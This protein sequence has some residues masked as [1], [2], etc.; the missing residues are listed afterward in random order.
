MEWYQWAATLGIPSI[1]S[2]L[3]CGLIMLKI[4]R[5]IARSDEE[6]KLADAAAKTRDAEI[7]AQN[8]TMEK[9][10]RAMM[11]GMQAM[12]RD[13]LLQAYRHYETKGWAD[14]DDRENLENIY[15]QYHA[16][17]ANGIM[18]EYRNRFLALPTTP[19]ATVA[20]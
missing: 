9:Q 3:I 18:D 6:K 14:Y 19:P 12:L 2:G 15:T 16:L 13:R 11:L 17:G 4:N 8:E 1:I 20:L 7:K 10:N 5:T